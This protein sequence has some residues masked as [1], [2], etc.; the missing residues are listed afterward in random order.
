[1]A[2]IECTQVTFPCDPE[3]SGGDLRKEM[4]VSMSIG[5]RGDDRSSFLEVIWC[6]GDVLNIGTKSHP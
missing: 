1:M 3:C 6:G 4:H 5:P 2:T